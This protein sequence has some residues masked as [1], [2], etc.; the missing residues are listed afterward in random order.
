MKPSKEDLVTVESDDTEAYDVRPGM[1][2][3]SRKSDASKVADW[4]EARNLAAEIGLQI[5]LQYS[6]SGG[7]AFVIYENDKPIRT[8]VAAHELLSYFQ[9]RRDHK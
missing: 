2:G 5:K 8:E 3:R 6:L 7:P 4:E 1:I 9:G